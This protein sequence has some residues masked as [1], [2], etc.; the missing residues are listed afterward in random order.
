MSI[1]EAAY[2]TEILLHNRKDGSSFALHSLEIFSVICT[3][4]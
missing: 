3:L 2:L 1:T 4:Y